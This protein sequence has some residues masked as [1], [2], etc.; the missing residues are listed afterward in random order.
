MLIVN[1]D[2]DVVV[3]LKK[4]RELKKRM[5][6]AKLKIFPNTDHRYSDQKAKSK[7]VAITTEYAVKS[8]K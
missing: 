7:L 3:P 6:N 2:A 5:Q 1:G 8:G 4:T